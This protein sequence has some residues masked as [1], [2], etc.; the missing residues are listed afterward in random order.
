MKFPLA[1]RSSLEAIGHIFDKGTP[2]T[3]INTLLKSLMLS[4]HYVETHQEEVQKEN[5]V[6]A[7]K[8]G[9]LRT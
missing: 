9:Y 2:F 5:K 6:S 8:K 3:K 1:A 7:N 4:S